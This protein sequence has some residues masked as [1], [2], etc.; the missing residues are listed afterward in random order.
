MAAPVT[1]NIQRI[2]AAVNPRV[3]RH[4]VL[5]ACAGA[6]LLAACAYGGTEVAREHADDVTAAIETAAPEPSPD[7]RVLQVDSA[8]PFTGIAVLA[9]PAPRLPLPWTADDAVS[10]SLG[11]TLGDQSTAA[12]IEAATGV[13]VRFQGHRPDDAPDDPFGLPATPFGAVAAG[14]PEGGIWTGPLDDLLDTWTATRGYAW[15]WKP[16]T[17]HIEVVRSQ[18]VAWTLNALA[19]TQSIDGATSTTESAGEGSS[20]NLARQSMAASATYDPWTEVTAQ[21]AAVLDASATIAASPSTASLTVHGLPRDIGR[22]RNYLAW[23]NRTILRPVTV[24][25]SI[26]RVAFESGADYELGIAGT[27]ERVFGTSVGL[28]VL[29]GGISIVQPAPGIDSLDAAIGALETAGTVSRELTATVPSLNAQ[30]SHFFELFSETYLAEISTSLDQ[31]VV[32]TALTPGTVSSGFAMEFVA[33]IVAP[34]EVLVRIFASI[35]DRPD[36]TT[37]GTGTLRLQLPSF[38][39]RAVQITQ[40]VGRGETLVIT[41]F[42]DRGTKAA[43]S[44]TFDADVPFPFGSRDID[45]DFTEQVLLISAEAG[46]PM[47]VVERSGEEL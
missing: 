44:G 26:Y 47:G 14:L 33:Q 42:R 17:E 12:L 15:R 16:E 10:L 13:A 32:E 18:A 7:F 31:G 34:H 29:S 9:P 1:P 46:P 43:G 36:F 5:P 37:F 39:N 3:W 11:G 19:G 8:R 35:L 6:I 20:T 27:L 21:L 24:T 2:G 22:A 4:D 40:T 30:P 28:E 25:F 38:G 41:G 45:D 23:L